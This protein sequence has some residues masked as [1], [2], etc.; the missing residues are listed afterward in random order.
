MRRNVRIAAKALAATLWMAT[1]LTSPLSAAPT[2]YVFEGVLTEVRVNGGVIPAGYT[3]GSRFS[4]SVEFDVAALALQPPPFPPLEID[5][6]T[7]SLATAKMTLVIGGDTIPGDPAGDLEVGIVNDVP[8]GGGGLLDGVLFYARG[9]PGNYGNIGGQYVINNPEMQLEL[10]DLSSLIFQ[11]TTVPAMIDDV[12]FDL[13][14]LR[15][16][17][18]LAVPNS[19]AYELLGR[20]DYF[21]LDAATPGDLNED[22]RVDIF[23]VA[24]VSNHWGE[25][26]PDGDA[27]EDGV[28]DIFDV[29]LIS[30]HWNPGSATPTPEPSTAA[31]AF[32][33]GAALTLCM[34]AR[35]PRP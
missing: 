1:M 28:V 23:D 10:I 27:N 25:S 7:Q 22:G 12:L 15:L 19:S 16:G 35:A 34:H 9:A 5:L 11:D 13:M 20:L 30:N 17:D 3:Q 32:L 2:R 31:L 18:N 4:G 21:A 33:C 29:A 6:Y 8:D 14:T 24:I 26:G